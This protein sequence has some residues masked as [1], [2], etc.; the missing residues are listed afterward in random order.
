MKRRHQ[1]L[2]LAPTHRG[3]PSD[4]RPVVATPP[5]LPGAPL[6]PPPRDTDSPHAVT[7]SYYEAL[8]SG[9]VTQAG[10]AFLFPDD[11]TAAD[12]ARVELENRARGM[13]AGTLLLEA[14]RTRA[15]GRWAVV[16]ERFEARRRTGAVDRDLRPV[17]LMQRGAV[18]RIVGDAE[19]AAARTSSTD[20]DF[21]A[22][23]DWFDGHLDELRA[24]YLE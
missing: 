24:L 16:V 15:Q 11:A 12:R 19:G 17:F 2:V 10:E 5:P 6:P 22:L 3:Q 21:R 18:W 7:E 1:A 4:P 8:R 13:S 14:V 23:R 9:D 20:D